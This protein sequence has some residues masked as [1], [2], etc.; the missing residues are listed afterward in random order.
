MEPQ[1]DWGADPFATHYHELTTLADRLTGVENLNVAVAKEGD[2][3]IFL[4]KILPGASDRSYGIEV[5][6]LAGIPEAV[7]A[8][9][10]EILAELEAK[11]LREQSQTVALPTKPMQ[12]SLFAVD[13]ARIYDELR[14]LDLNT[15]APLEA[16]KLLFKWQQRL[17]KKKEA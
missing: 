8:R 6:R 3:I 11:G 17:K 16:L 15:I 13:E 12:L 10:A 7:L 9:A 2:G 1:A 5:A 4:H 14:Q